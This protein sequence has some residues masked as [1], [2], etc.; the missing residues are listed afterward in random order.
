M[1]KLTLLAGALFGLIACGC[2]SHLVFL[3]EDH[4]GLK[5]AFEPNNPSPAQVSIAYR[6]GVVAV[7][8]QQSLAEVRTTNAVNV[9][10][11]QTNGTTVVTVTQDPN[12]LMSLYTTFRANVGLGNPIYVQHFL[13]T[14]NAA[15][16]LLANHTALSQL[17]SNL[18]AN[19]P[20]QG[21]QP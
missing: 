17:T 5:V 14:G 15:S 9:T 19:P 11:V 7:V 3:E 12:E 1:T 2:T 13:A 10:T 21:K 8:P 18:N 16:A 6:R 4:A 20:S